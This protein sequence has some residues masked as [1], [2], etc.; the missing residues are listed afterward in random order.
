MQDLKVKYVYTHHMHRT[1][2]A[3]RLQLIFTMIF[4]SIKKMEIIEMCSKIPYIGVYISI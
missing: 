4:F 3:F 2:R 1:D